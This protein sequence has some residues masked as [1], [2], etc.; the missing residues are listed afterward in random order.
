VGALGS[1]LLAV[2]FKKF[3]FEVLKDVLYGTFNT[4]AY[5]FGIFVGA[6]AFALVL[7]GLGGDEVISEVLTSLPFGPT[8]T[9][10]VILGVVFL[11]GF[12]LDWVEI[13]L[14]VLPLLAPVIPHL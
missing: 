11:L 2:M 12:F 1:L 14:I 10:L 3:N 6:T 8:G 5:I 4:T 9:I 7:R 13:T